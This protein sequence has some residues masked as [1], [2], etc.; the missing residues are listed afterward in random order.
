[1]CIK[2]KKHYCKQNFFN[3]YKMNNQTNN[4]NNSNFKD[5]SKEVDNSNSQIAKQININLPKKNKLYYLLFGSL[6]KKMMQKLSTIEFLIVLYLRILLIITAGSLIM[7]PMFFYNHNISDIG[8]LIGT[9]YIGTV[10]LH[11]KIK[12]I[13]FRI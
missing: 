13:L 6:D 12:N 2:I 11:K 5:S 3:L 4:F 10:L 9:F 8:F 1:M 7:I